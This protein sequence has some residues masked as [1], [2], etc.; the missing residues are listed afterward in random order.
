VA[1]FTPRPARPIKAGRF[2]RALD[3]IQRLP[4]KMIN[5]DQPPNLFNVPA[6]ETTPALEAGAARRR[7]R[8]WQPAQVHINTA[9]R[10]AG[11]TAL[12]RARWL[13]RNNGY[14]KS[15]ITSW[16]AATVGAGI[17][18]TPQVNDEGLQERITQEFLDWTDEA[19]AE[20]L[21]DFYGVTR[22]VAR[23]AYIAGECFVRF[24]PRLP[25]DGLRIP[26]QLQVLPSEQLPLTQVQP[27][28][29]GY[30]NDGGEIRMGVEFHRNLRDKRVAYWFLR[31]NP[32]DAT[33]SFRDLLATDRL[34]RI[35][36]DEIIHVY[37]P[38][39]AGQVRGLTRFAASVV[40]LFML[41]AWDDAELERQKQVSNYASFI[42]K[43]AENDLE[44]GLLVNQRNPLD[45]PAILMPGTIM[46][47]FAGEKFTH[48][49]PPGVAGT[50]EPFQYRV[51]LA[52][53]AGLGVPYAEL[54]G[55]LNRTTYASSRAGLLAF[56]SEIEAFQNAVLIFQFIRRTWIRWM[57]TAVLVGALPISAQ[58][59]NANLRHYRK[60]K[61]IPPRAPWVDPLKDRQAIKLALDSQTMSLQDAIAAEGSDIE[62]VFRQ[63]AEENELR[64]KYG[65]PRPSP[66]WGGRALGASGAAPA[67][68]V[69]DASERDA[70]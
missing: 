52:L 32:T 65:I 21:T 53:C 58:A 69:E 42:E 7:L 50:Y 55:D 60:M 36:A 20:E 15:A 4:K 59:Y 12:A 26:L 35:P 3:V 43:P 63:I 38:V 14:G 30:G 47:G 25:Q 68:T 64:E 51:L 9:L 31:A 19:D 29:T 1:K 57:D 39:E 17:T 5:G 61:A 48:M 66:G 70:A 27:A 37:D 45:D 67:P 28:P 10:N 54:T 6:G 18:P 2:W 34:V 24:R 40:K 56:R 46:E 49:Q 22:R 62:T 23:E 13:G 44:T 33:V 41:D 11:P 16:T 8:L